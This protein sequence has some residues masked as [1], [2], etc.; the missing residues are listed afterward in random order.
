MVSVGFV[1]PWSDFTTLLVRG[2]AESLKVGVEL[3]SWRSGNE[4]DWHP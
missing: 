4:P 1:W 2:F 3:P